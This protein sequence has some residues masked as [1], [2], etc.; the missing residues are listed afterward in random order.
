[1]KLQSYLNSLPQTEEEIVALLSKE[2]IK[3]I[4]GK[5][6]R[7]PIA[8]LL[9]RKGF[10]GVGVGTYTA[11][12]DFDPRLDKLDT[13]TLPQAVVSFIKSFDGGKYPELIKQRTF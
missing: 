9:F 10:H 12:C 5:A 4:T 11:N 8:E 13:A 1:M 3:G 7:C 2:G 6:C